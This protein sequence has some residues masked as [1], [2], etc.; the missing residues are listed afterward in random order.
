MADLA[1]W[2]GEFKPWKGDDDRRVLFLRRLIGV[3]HDTVAYAISFRIVPDDFHSVNAL[4][5][6]AQQYTQ[7]PYPFATLGAVLDVEDWRPG[8]PLDA[9]TMHFI[10]KGDDGQGC[11]AEL[12][13]NGIDRVMLLPKI[14][15]QTG[16][17]FTPFQGADFL[18]YEHRRWIRRHLAGEQQKI[19][20]C[21]RALH[22]A[23]PIVYV[24]MTRADMIAQCQRFP[25]KYPRRFLQIGD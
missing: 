17:Y 3:L 25:D 21:W 6:L 22:A 1:G 23:I 7:S 24:R 15:P 5:H 16:E 11:I 19:R 8:V 4:F 14:D 9:P 18:A 20:K 12:I 2:A 13:A 10:E